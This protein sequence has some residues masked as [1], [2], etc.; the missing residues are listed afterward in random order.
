MI[1]YGGLDR[2]EKV[3]ETFVYDTKT[4]KLDVVEFG[5]EPPPQRFGHT[6]TLVSNDRMVVIGGV[7][8]QAGFMMLL[9]PKIYILNLE[10]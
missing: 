10:S 2:K 5:T 8:G 4:K 3:A 6:A 9:D 1:I 7:I